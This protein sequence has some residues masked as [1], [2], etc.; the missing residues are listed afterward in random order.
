MRWSITKSLLLL[1]V[2]LPLLC[3][4]QEYTS[5]TLPAS[6]AMVTPRLSKNE[7]FVKRFSSTWE[8]LIP[9]YFK[10][11]FAGSIGIF[12]VGTGWDYG[13]HRQW[14]TDVMLGLIPRCSSRRAKATFTLRQYYI[15]WNIQLGMYKGDDYSVAPLRCCLFFNTVYGDEFWTQEPDRYPSGYYNFSTRIRIGCSLGQSVT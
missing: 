2:A 6:P 13:H 8:S 7:R 4:A 12:S 15:P 11:Q 9:R 10:F 14:E 5:D 1:V 3:G